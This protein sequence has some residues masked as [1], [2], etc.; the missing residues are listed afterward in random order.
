MKENEEKE[1][2]VNIEHYT[3]EKPIE[4][5]VRKGD[6]AKAVDPLPELEPL[7]CNLE[8]TIEAPA[9]WLEKRA[10]TLDGKHMYAVVDR[11]AMSI[12]LVVNETDARTKRTIVGKAEY[13]EVYE[14][15]RINDAEGWEPAKLGQFIRLHRAFFDDK[16]KATELVAKLKKFTAKVKSTLEKAEDRDGSRAIAY[17]QEVE[18]NL[19]KD[20]KVCIPI[21]KGKEKQLVEVEIDHYIQGAVCYLQLFSPEALDVIEDSTD[22]LLNTEIERMKKAVP[23]IVVIEGSLKDNGVKLKAKSED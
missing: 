5:I 8:G 23:D 1:V 7:K 6:A 22:R 9:N 19:P 17:Q 3:G 11:E 16:S 15:F 13:S 4:V 20:F 18:S 21:F 14:S 12:G 2:S 10:D